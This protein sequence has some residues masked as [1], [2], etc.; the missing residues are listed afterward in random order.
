[1]INEKFYFFLLTYAHP[2]GVSTVTIASK[3][4]VITQRIIDSHKPND[5]TVL[6]GVYCFGKMTKEE[7]NNG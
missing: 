5:E 1:M 6:V 3:L 2:D 7:F 4:K